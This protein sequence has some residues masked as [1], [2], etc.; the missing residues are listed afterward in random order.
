MTDML[1]AAGFIDIKIQVKENAA[2]IIKD[3]MPGSDAEKYVTSAYVTA[4]KPSGLHGIRDDVRADS[5]EKDV[6]VA[7]GDCGEGACGPGA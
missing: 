2:D 3:W 7:T 4:R 1:S 5:N 6:A